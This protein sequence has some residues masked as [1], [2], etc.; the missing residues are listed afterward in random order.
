[1]GGR[2]R[3]DYMV[4]MESAKRIAMMAGTAKG[5]EV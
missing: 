2:N 4:L 1:M 5:D 3:I